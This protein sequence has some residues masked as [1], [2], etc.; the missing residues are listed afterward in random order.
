MKDLIE[1][2]VYA[3]E[4][5]TKEY[6]CFGN[7]F[8]PKNKSKTLIR[9]LKDKR[10]L[11]KGKFSWNYENCPNHIECKKE[12]HAIN[13]SEIHF[14]GMGKNKSKFL[15]IIYNNWLNFLY[16]NC[17]LN[18]KHFYFKI[19]Y[20]ELEKLNKAK[21]G[22]KK[23]IENIYNRFYRSEIEG[24]AKYFFNRYYNQIIIDTIYHDSSDA[25]EMHEYFPWHAG[26]KINSKD[27]KKLYIK[28]EDIVFLDSNHRKY[29]DSNPYLASKN[30]RK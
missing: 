10:C 28:N 3:D 8:V 12:R 6:V 13:N 25:K 4:I 26:H 1:L 24:G 27:D 16:E 23:A 17:R 14:S 15:K 19:T 21:F 29:I 11:T 20:Y 9:S 22:L 2:E 30:L 7:L 5:I 18:S